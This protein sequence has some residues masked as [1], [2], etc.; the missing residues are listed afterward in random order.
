[1]NFDIS[2][3]L[4]TFNRAQDLGKTLEGM[5]KIEKGDL[6]VEFVVVDNGSTDQTKLVVDLFSNRIP[7]KYIFEP[8]SGKNRA[9]NTALEK[10]D[11]GKIVVF[12]DDD[13]D[14]P[15]DWLVSIHSVCER[16]P[17]HA[18]FG[19]RINIVFPFENVPNWAS[20][21]FLSSVGFSYHNYSNE[22]C[23]YGDSLTPFG[24]N[25]WVRRKVFDQGRRFNEAIGPRPKNRMMGSETYFLCGLLKDN[26]EIVYSPRVAVGHRIQ[27]ETLKI[28]AICSR[29]YRLGR[30]EAHILGL[31]GQTLLRH[32]HKLW[33]LYRNGSIIWYGI[34]LIASFIFSTKDQRPTNVV[35]KF[36]GLGYRIESVRLAKKLLL[37]ERE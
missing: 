14:A 9:L 19:G 18:V 23:V 29:G 2:I 15:P 37:G 30:G 31:P 17:N 21:P 36:R 1:L 11:L 3:I 16:W 33:R 34:K 10:C 6:T 35:Q 25:F 12:T 27:P 4:A 20:D 28:S 13:V 24:P 32:N 5:A 7:I 8:R 26:Y 22:E